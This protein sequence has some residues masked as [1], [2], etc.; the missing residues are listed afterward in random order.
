MIVGLV[1]DDV[2]LKGRYIGGIKV[3]G[4]INEVESIVAE[5]GADAVVIAC[6]FSDDWM[7]VV[8]KLLEPTGVRVSRFSFS[9]IEVVPGR[10]ERLST[11]TKGAK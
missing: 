6:D 4:T 10:N 1:D 11:K 2:Y 8:M 9:E 3:M 7:K 5:T